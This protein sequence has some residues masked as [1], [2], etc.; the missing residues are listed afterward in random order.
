MRYIN[1]YSVYVAD[2]VSILPRKCSTQWCELFNR[3]EC[4]Q[5]NTA[6]FAISRWPPPVVR[7]MIKTIK[8]LI[9]I[10][11]KSGN[12]KHKVAK[13]LCCFEDIFISLSI[14]N[15]FIYDY[16][17]QDIWFNWDENLTLMW[18]FSCYNLLLPLDTKWKRTTENLRQY[19][20]NILRGQ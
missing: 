8:W 15:M 5:N 20:A 2:V 4:L 16:D 17:V 12:T 14:Y 6:I 1:L 11:L 19:L 13:C 10:W 18:S 9:S 3:W 7:F